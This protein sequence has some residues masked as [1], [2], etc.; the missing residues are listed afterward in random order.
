MR[1]HGL[2]PSTQAGQS[3]GYKQALEYL[4]DVWGF[5]GPKESSD[6]PYEVKVVLIGRQPLCYDHRFL[7]EK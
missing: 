6:K 5:T 3:I 7:R 2:C 4:S 1:E